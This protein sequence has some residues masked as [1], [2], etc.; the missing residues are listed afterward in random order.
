MRCRD[1]VAGK[2][3]PPLIQSGKLHAHTL[4]RS[5]KGEFIA[6]LRSPITVPD[7]FAF[8]TARLRQFGIETDGG[9]NRICGLRQMEWIL[10]DP[11][12]EELIN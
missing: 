1:N 6:R 5:S 2:Q 3:R 9:T 10:L 12:S 4:T 8:C 7:L 11:K